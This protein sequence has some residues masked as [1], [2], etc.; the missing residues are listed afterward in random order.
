[1]APLFRRA[2]S[3]D[4]AFERLYKRHVKDVYRYSLAVLGEQS[5][6]E[7]VTQATFMNAYRAFQRGERPEKPENWLITIAH[8]VCRQRFRQ[9]QHRPYEVEFNDA[10]GAAPEEHEGPSAEDLRRAFSQLPANQ[11]KALV[12]R[13]LEGRSYAEIAAILGISVSALETLIFRARRSLREQLEE[14]LTCTEAAFA[15]SKEADGRLTSEEQRALRAHIRACP[16]CATAAHSQRAMRRALTSMLAVPLPHSL[17]SFF[18]GGA[19]VAA[20]AAGA[21]ATAIGLKAAAVLTAGAVIGGGTYVGMA[22]VHPLRDRHQPITNSAT[23]LPQTTTQ[24]ISD[25]AERLLRLRGYSAKTQGRTFGQRVHRSRA[26]TPRGQKK[27]A[28]RSGRAHSLT[29]RNRAAHATAAPKQKRHHPALPQRK[30]RVAP[31]ARPTAPA[32]GGKSAAA[33]STHNKK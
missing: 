14:Q 1:M 24:V 16:D 3:S 17:A 19:G 8:N 20:S 25:G 4:A 5:D 23:P 7:D 11:R 33:R 18:G 15:I 21:G 28:S 30:A 32:K 22:E 26:A 10:A 27:T 2:A 6:A 9:A 31:S 13:E 29:S 12:M